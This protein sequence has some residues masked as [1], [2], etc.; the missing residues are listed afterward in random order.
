MRTKQKEE[1]IELSSIELEKVTSLKPCDE[2]FVKIKLLRSIHT[3]SII[4][5]RLMHPK[6]Q[7]KVNKVNMI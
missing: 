2:P 6:C 3:K 1:D 4:F 5:V 7:T